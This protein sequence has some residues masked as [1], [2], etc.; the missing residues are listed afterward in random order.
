M[1]DAFDSDFELSLPYVAAF[2]TAGSN[3]F[4]PEFMEARSIDRD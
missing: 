1:S 3:D 2:Y 4:R